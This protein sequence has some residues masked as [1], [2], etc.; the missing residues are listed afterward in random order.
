MYTIKKKPAKKIN[1]TSHKI[2]NNTRQLA[3]KEKHDVVGTE[4]KS[5]KH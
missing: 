5:D 2:T 4:E 3:G 1:A